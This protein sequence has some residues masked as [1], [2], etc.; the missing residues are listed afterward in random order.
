MDLG[1]RIKKMNSTA[2][3]AG[4]TQATSVDEALVAATKCC[5]RRST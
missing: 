5:Q 1:D 3:N 4:D 2:I